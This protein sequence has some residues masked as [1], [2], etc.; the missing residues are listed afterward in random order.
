[1]LALK[2]K[3]AQQPGSRSHQELEEGLSQTLQSKPHSPC[4]NSHGGPEVEPHSIPPSPHQVCGGHLHGETRCWDLE[5][6]P[7]GRKLEP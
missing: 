6:K 4:L 3:E 1:M 7:R 5:Y 2:V